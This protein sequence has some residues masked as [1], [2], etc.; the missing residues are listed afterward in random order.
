MFNSSLKSENKSTLCVISFDAGYSWT[1]GIIMYINLKKSLLE[2]FLSAKYF[3]RNIS[4]NSVVYIKFLC[5]SNESL[6][7]GTIN[8]KVVSMR[9]QAIT[10]K[11]EKKSSFINN[12]KYERFSVNYAARVETE[13]GEVFM[14]ILNDLSL[15]GIRFFTNSSIEENKKICI[16]I[17]VSDDKSIFFSG[18]ILR[19]SSGKVGYNYAMQFEDVDDNSADSLKEILEFLS[20][21]NR[22]VSQE[23]DLFNKV[24]ILAYISLTLL[25]ILVVVGFLY[26]EN[27]IPHT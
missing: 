6:L 10:V 22:Y 20:F 15:G 16:E 3:E 12:R 4:K 11:I 17:L 24:K 23:M 1:Q 7:I 13:C 14:V 27:L 9:K 18:E 8:K 21:Q 26:K 25:L 5:N 19:K 2:I